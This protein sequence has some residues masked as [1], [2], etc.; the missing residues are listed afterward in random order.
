MYRL[1]EI[2]LKQGSKKVRIP[3]LP[4]EYSV[5]SGQ[6]NTVVN[7]NALGEINLKGKRGLLNIGFSSFFPITADSYCEYQD[8]DTPKEYVDKIERM[9]RNG[10]VK[11]IITGTSINLYTTIESFTWG[12]NDGTGDINYSLD[13]MEYRNLRISVSILQTEQ[14]QIP[15]TG[16]ARPEPEQ[17]A[18]QN[19]VVKQGD[20]LSSIAVKMTGSADWRAIYEQNKAVIGA[21]PNRIFAGQVLIIPGAKRT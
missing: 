13:F 21:N 9:K 18:T 3:V 7:V 15:V 6:V 17:A 14:P 16:A 11:L 1:R 2:W 20:C 8:I 4:P 19:Y 10:N 5:T 12:E